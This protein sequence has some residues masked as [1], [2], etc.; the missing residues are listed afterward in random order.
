M[1][2]LPP[3]FDGAVFAAVSVQRDG[4]A[5]TLATAELL[6]QERRPAARHVLCYA[7]PIGGRHLRRPV[8]CVRGS[9]A[10]YVL[11]PSA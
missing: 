5:H 2:S 10:T 3:D 6:A 9:Y 11:F 8:G 4:G 1:A 7:E